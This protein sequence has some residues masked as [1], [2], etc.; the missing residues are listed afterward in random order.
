VVIEQQALPCRTDL[1]PIEGIKLD[2]SLVVKRG[3]Y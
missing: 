2:N 3:R 1:C